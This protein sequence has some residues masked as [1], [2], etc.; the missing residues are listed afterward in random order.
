MACKVTRDTHGTLW[1]VPQ[2]KQV[3][4]PGS[5]QFLGCGALDIWWDRDILNRADEN[6]IIRQDNGTE[7]DADVIQITL[8]QAYDLLHA[9]GWAIKTP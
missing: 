9:L 5:K 4:T 7:E 6:I 1:H 2:Q 3:Q 8:G